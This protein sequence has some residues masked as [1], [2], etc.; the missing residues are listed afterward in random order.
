MERM[1]EM[2]ADEAMRWKHAIFRLM[3]RWGLEPDDLL[4]S[5]TQGE[6]RRRSE[7]SARDRAAARGLPHM[8]GTVGLAIRPPFSEGLTHPCQGASLDL[9]NPLAREIHNFAGLPKRSRAAAIEPEA[10]KDHR[11]FLRIQFAESSPE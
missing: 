4:T 11:P 1:G 5:S 7:A 10:V 2:S 8:P 6:L 3:E 9:P